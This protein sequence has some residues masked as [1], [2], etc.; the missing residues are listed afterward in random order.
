MIINKT[1]K[2]DEIGTGNSGMVVYTRK[3]STLETIPCI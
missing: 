2:Y 1:T 3:P